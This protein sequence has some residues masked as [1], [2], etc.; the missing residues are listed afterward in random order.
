MLLANTDDEA[1]ELIEA[2]DADP[3]RVEV[4]HP[5]VDLALF[6][7]RAR[8]RRAPGSAYRS[9]R[10]CWSSSAGSSRS[11]RPTSWSGRPPSCSSATR[12]CATSCVVAIVGGPSGSGLERPEALCDLAASL[13]LADRVRFVPPVGR[14]ELVDWYAAA[15]AVCVPS[16]NESFGLVAVEAQAVGT[17][18]VAAA[19]GGLTTAVADGRSGLLVRGPRPGRL[20]PCAGDGSCAS[21]GCAPSCRRTPCSTPPTSAGR[22]RRT[23]PSR[24]TAGPPPACAPT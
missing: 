3:D 8:T 23:A 18:V 4:V 22:V 2:Y 12:R 9:T 11:R 10:T 17:P 21:P 6:R 19:V 1:R 7:P 13:G 24:S 20:R 5:G 16:Y 14:D 15:D